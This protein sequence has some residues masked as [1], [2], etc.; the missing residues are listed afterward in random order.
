MAASKEKK[1]KKKNTAAKPL[2]NQAAIGAA[3]RAFGDM[4]KTDA[5]N[6]RENS[7]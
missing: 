1:A 4:A 6:R 3:T 7:A 2:A 5:K